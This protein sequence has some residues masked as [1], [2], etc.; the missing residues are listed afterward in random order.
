MEDRSIGELGLSTRTCN[1]L[2]GYGGAEIL[3]LSDLLNQTE[4]NLLAI[5]GFG[6]VALQEVINALQLIGLSLAESE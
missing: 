1:L 2:V 4:E 5:C 3:N 6:A